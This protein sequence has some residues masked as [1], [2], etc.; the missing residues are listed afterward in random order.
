MPC[1]QPIRANAAVLESGEERLD[2]VTALGVKQNGRPGLVRGGSCRF[3]QRAGVPGDD[4]FI[5]HF[6]ETRAG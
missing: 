5:T 2:I 3:H 4:A 1:I 6:D